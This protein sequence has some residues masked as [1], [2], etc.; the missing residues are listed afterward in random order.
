MFPFHLVLIAILICASHS[1]WTGADSPLI[2]KKASF[3]NDTGWTGFQNHLVATF[4]PR[5]LQ[6]FG[7]RTSNLAGKAP[8]EIGGYIQSSVR[9]AHYAKKLGPLSMDTPLS[10]SGGFV[11]ME[12][13]SIMSYHTLCETYIGF[14]NSEEQGWRPKN[15]MGIRF[16]GTNEPDGVLIEITYTTRRRSAN[17]ALLEKG[18]SV[19][20]T[21]LIK[22]LDGSRMLRI[23]PDGKRHEW[24]FQ[25]NPR[26]QDKEG[27]IVFTLDGVRWTISVERSHIEVGAE[28]NR[29]GMF[30]EQLPGRAMVIYF[31]DIV[32]NREAEDFSNDPGWEAIGNQ[33]YFDDTILYGTNDFGFSATSYAGGK[34]GEIG[35]RLWRVDKSESHLK[36]WYGIDVGT[37][38]LNDR[39]E[40]HGVIC[41]RRFCIDSGMHLG[42]FNSGEQGWPPKNFVGVNLDSLSRVGLLFMPMYG[43]KEGAWSIGDEYNSPHFVD[44]GTPLKWSIVYDPQ[45]IQ[46]LGSVTVTLGDQSSTISLKPGEK[47]QGAVMNR[48][49]IF[50]MQDNNGKYCE[51]YLDDIEYSSR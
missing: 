23:A 34:T 35:G 7:Y 37:L 49:G 46:G 8:G 40:A 39:L 38:T 30:N 48:F 19:P 1:A 41:I 21:G 24:T 22:E 6:D 17:G 51:V 20:Q 29:F 42:F 44:D 33:E 31:D 16:M 27:E 9:P 45:A 32:I 28:F 3:D 14:F 4:P 50:N 26:E 11:L 25:Y 12:G 43:A 2:L 13:R 10:F 18:G 36:A 15:F 5:L 47:D